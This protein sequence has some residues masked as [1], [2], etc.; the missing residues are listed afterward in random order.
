MVNCEKH[1]E[2]Y[3]IIYECKETSVEFCMECYIEK[4]K[5][6]GLKDYGKSR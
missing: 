3:S 4:L 5:E 2:T 6:F 1:R